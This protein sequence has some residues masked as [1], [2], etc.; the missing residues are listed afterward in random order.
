MALAGISLVVVMCG[1]WKKRGEAGR[2]RSAG[3][4]SPM[5]QDDAVY[6]HVCVCTCIRHECVC[7]HAQS[8]ELF[9]AVFGPLA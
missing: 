8:C 4:P 3:W 7:P 6:L 2:V 9:H 5:C 1:S